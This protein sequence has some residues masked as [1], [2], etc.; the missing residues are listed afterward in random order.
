MSENCRHCEKAL[1]ERRQLID[2]CSYSCRGQHTV[3][4]LEAPTHQTGLSGA[5][6]AR[7]HRE[8]RSLKR[9]SGG[10]STFEQIN[11]VTYRMDA[12][13]KVAA[14]WLMEVGR[15]GWIACVGE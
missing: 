3:K 2:F 8:L 15:P 9:R 14:G 11:A 1:P 6:N 4:A 12:P 10:R 13:R 7:K 5:K